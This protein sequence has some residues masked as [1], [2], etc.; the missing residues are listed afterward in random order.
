MLWLGCTL[1]YPIRVV[2]AWVSFGI[3][4]FLGLRS[5]TDRQYGIDTDMIRVVRRDRSQLDCLSVFSGYTTYQIVLGVPLG[6]PK[7][8]SVLLGSHVTRVRERAS[9]WAEVEVRAK[10]S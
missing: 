3:T 1:T 7:T 10:A 5:P 4:T 9:S 2:F 8:C 6:S